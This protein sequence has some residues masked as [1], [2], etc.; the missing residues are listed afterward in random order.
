MQQLVRLDPVLGRPVAIA[1]S[2]LI[3]LIP[4]SRIVQQLIEELDRRQVTL[5][6]HCLIDR[7]WVS[8][9]VCADRSAKARKKG[10][11]LT[12]RGGR[13]PV[14]VSSEIP[15]CSG[16]CRVLRVSNLTSR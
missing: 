4:A 11:R 14:Q 16:I 8:E 10:G 9:I 12:D 2:F 3:R 13:E 7:V 6:R 5:D 15:V 1:T